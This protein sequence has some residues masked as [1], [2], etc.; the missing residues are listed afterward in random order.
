MVNTFTI[1]SRSLLIW[2]VQYLPKY[3][4]EIFRNPFAGSMFLQCGICRLGDN[5]QLQKLFRV[6]VQ[7]FYEK[8]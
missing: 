8:S 7:Y 1:V 5:D 2:I 3:S 6:I 4:L